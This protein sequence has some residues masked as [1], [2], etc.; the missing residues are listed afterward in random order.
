MGKFKNWKDIKKELNFRP[1]EIE[2]MELEKIIK[3]N[4]VNKKNKI[5]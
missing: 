5:Y 4:I 1:E 3:K 2:E